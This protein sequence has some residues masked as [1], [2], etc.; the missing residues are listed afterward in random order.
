MTYK[1]WK[2]YYYIKSSKS[3][4]FPIPFGLG[5]IGISKYLHWYRFHRNDEIT[6]VEL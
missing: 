1:E 6:G 2:K 4:G 3:C 5:I